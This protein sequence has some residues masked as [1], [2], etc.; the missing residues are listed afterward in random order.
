MLGRKDITLPVS[1]IEGK[2]SSIDVNS[3]QIR[4]QCKSDL[5]EIFLNL[6]ASPKILRI[7]C[8]SFTIRYNDKRGVLKEVGAIYVLFIPGFCALQLE[9]DKRRYR[10]VMDK[11]ISGHYIFYQCIVA[12]L[13]IVVFFNYTIIIRYNMLLL[14]RI[15]NQYCMYI[16]KFTDK[17]CLLLTCM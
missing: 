16:I 9:A 2:K 13:V 10:W 6:F 5:L 14:H 17:Y 1:H 3:R 15:L 7:N 8:F 11:L 12:S 4:Q